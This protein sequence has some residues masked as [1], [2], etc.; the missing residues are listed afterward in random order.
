MS[1]HQFH[2]QNVPSSKEKPLIRGIQV[3][4]NLK[5][6][7][8]SDLKENVGYFRLAFNPTFRG[9]GNLLNGDIIKTIYPKTISKGQFQSLPW[10]EFTGD[11]LNS[12]TDRDSY[13]DEIQINCEYY[14]GR[15]SYHP[16]PRYVSVQPF[17]IERKNSAYSNEYQAVTC[18]LNSYIVMPTYPDR[19]TPTVD[20][21]LS[22]NQD[23]Y[24]QDGY[25]IMDVQL[26]LKDHV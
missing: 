25:I 16:H 5:N 8:T 10:F 20:D 23:G 24:I 26:V 4:L 7:S 22:P 3:R 2:S 21:L 13:L 1:L 17:M 12:V 14:G 15:D 19:S 18:V 11:K 6:E 9:F